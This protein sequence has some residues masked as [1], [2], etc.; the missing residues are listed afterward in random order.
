M[1]FVVFNSFNNYINK[2]NYNILTIMIHAMMG[3]L[4]GA[5]IGNVIYHYAESDT[6]TYS[7]NVPHDLI[8]IVL[9]LFT[10]ASIGLGIDIAL[11]ATGSYLWFLP[12]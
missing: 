3:G 9:G 8:L 2:Y 12:K 4:L 11:L 7:H 1:I 10:G 5:G 6:R